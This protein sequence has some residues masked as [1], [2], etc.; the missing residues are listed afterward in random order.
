MM[1][2]I[3]KDIKG[4]EQLYQ[5]SNLGNVKSLSNNF[6]RKEKILKPKQRKGYLYVGLC[7]NGKRKYY[8]ANLKNL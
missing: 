4:F 5:I 1:N 8:S 3:W 6:S 7:K 2:E